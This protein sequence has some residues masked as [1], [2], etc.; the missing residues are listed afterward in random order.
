MGVGR[1]LPILADRLRFLCKTERGNPV[2]LRIG[3]HE[4]RNPW[5]QYMF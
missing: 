1:T 2:R 3:S 4:T 5:P